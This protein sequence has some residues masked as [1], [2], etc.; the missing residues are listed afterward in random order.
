MAHDLRPPLT[1]RQRAGVVGV[2]AGAAGW[3]V[4]AWTLQDK[5]FV[6]AV[7]ETAGATTAF[8]LLIS[9]AGAARA[10]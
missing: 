8:L 3:F 2:L 9:V 4:V 10:R 5:A 7:G 6:E 1:R